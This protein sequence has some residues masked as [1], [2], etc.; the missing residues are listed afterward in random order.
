[1]IYAYH[2]DPPKLDLY[3]GDDKPYHLE[4]NK[5]VMERNDDSAYLKDWIK[6]RMKDS[7]KDLINL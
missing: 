7:T 2:W 1:M 4:M 5:V 6:S 3:L